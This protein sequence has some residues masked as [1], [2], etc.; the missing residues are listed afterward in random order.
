MPSKWRISRTLLTRCAMLAG[1]SKCSENGTHKS[2]TGNLR[3]DPFRLFEVFR[4]DFGKRLV[5][6]LNTYY[7]LTS[8]QP[9]KL[10]SA[11]E[12]QLFSERSE[13]RFPFAVD[14]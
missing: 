5:L 3:S 6:D 1:C 7:V 13:D 9:L 2:L 10:L 14:Q 8:T 12:P 4:S 11:T